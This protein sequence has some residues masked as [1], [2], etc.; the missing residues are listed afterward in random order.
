M[1]VVF[2]STHHV[3]CF[4]TMLQ[5]AVTD[6]VE[7]CTGA[8]VLIFVVPHQFVTGICKQLIGKLEPNTQAISLIKVQ[9]SFFQNPENS[10]RA[11]PLLLILARFSVAIREFFFVVMVLWCAA[12]KL[13]PKIP[14][15][16]TLDDKCF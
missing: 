14:S 12:S 6:L 16:K 15:Q 5:V 10:W 8:N 2:F 11:T 4:T 1:R 9:L 3:N 13:L 7:S